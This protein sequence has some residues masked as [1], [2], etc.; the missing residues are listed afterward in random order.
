MH[1][2]HI[3]DGDTRVLRATADAD[4]GDI[5]AAITDGEATI[6]HL[7]CTPTGT[8]LLPAFTGRCLVRVG[9]APEA[10][11]GGLGGAL[12]ALGADVRHVSRGGR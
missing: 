3:R 7:M 10:V 12:V 8:W 1:D 6:K 5:I 4:N 11:S 9:R 2:A